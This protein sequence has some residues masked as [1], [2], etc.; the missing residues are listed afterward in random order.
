MTIDP[1]TPRRRSLRLPD[2]DY[3]QAGAYFITICTWNRACFFGEI[4]ENTVRLNA[5]G[6]IVQEEWQRTGEVRPYVSLDEVIVMP[7]HFHA[8]LVLTDL[9][10]ASAS[11]HPVGASRRDAR[12]TP[13]LVSG[14]LGAVVVQLKSLATKRIDHLRDTPGHSIW[15]RNYYEHVIRNEQ[16]MNLIRECT[17]NNPARWTEDRENPANF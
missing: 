4:A 7:N 17:Q 11:P 5:W 12:S 8:I 13:R 14:S 15:Q 6:L 10:N 2:Y 9:S 16:S 1:N 3:S